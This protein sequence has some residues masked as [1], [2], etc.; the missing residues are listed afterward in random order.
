VVSS[1]TS[2]FSDKSTEAASL[3][4]DE[5]PTDVIIWG[6]EQDAKERQEAM[7]HFSAMKRVNQ[8]TVLDFLGDIQVG[9]TNQKSLERLYN[10]RVRLLLLTPDFV[11]Q[12][13]ENPLFEVASNEIIKRHRPDRSGYRIIPILL[14][15]VDPE[16]LESD[17]LLGGLQPLPRNGMAISQQSKDEAWMKITNEVKAVLREYGKCLP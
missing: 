12:L 8:V 9:A 4:L 5:E 17:P 1:E 11:S 14:R 13:A 10:A 16:M 7:K 6:T 15:P 3:I 2:A